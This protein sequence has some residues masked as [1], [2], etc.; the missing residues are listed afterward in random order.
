MDTMLSSNSLDE[1]EDEDG[2]VSPALRPGGPVDLIHVSYRMRAT[3]ALYATRPLRLSISSRLPTHTLLRT[4]HSAIMTHFPLPLKV[5]RS[6]YRGSESLAFSLLLL[7]LW[8]FH[9]W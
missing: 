7:Q 6:Q 5:V 8:M 4:L 1:L 9:H 2:T 3:K